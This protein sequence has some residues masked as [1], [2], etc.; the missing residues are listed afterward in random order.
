MDVEV[1]YD[2]D[3]D[4]KPDRGFGRR[5][6]RLEAL[7][8]DY[9]QAAIDLVLS[10]TTAQKVWEWWKRS[11]GRRKNFPEMTRRL[12]EAIL[13][14][15]HTGGEYFRE[16][17]ARMFGRHKSAG[18]LPV[19]KFLEAIRRRRSRDL[20]LPETFVPIEPPPPPPTL[21]RVARRYRYPALPVGKKDSLFVDLR[22]DVV[23]IRKLLAKL[24]QL[25]CCRG[26]AVTANAD[27]IGHRSLVSSMPGWVGVDPFRHPP[28]SRAGRH[29]GREGNSEDPSVAQSPRHCPSQGRQFHPPR[30]K[31]AKGQARRLVQEAGR[32]LWRDDP[33]R[34][35]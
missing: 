27:R 17:V 31:D 6:I 24:V 33:Q 23:E 10:Q 21:S 29:F 5:M 3:F 14:E 20:P 34:A 22:R 25:L 26:E 2:R 4:L 7:S 11:L 15:F 8:G 16:M 18:K 9:T 35:A 12:V 30:W 28:E 32:D 19:G 13:Q 1:E